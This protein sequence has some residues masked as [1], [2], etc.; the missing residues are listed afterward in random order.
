MAALVPRCFLIQIGQISL[1][2]V[3]NFIP[4]WYQDCRW[5]QKH[6]FSPP[7]P[8]TS[9]WKEL[10]RVTSWW[11]MLHLY[12]C[13]SWASVSWL[14][15]K[16]TFP[17]PISV[18]HSYIYSKGNK[19]FWTRSSLAKQILADWKYEIQTSSEVSNDLS[20]TFSSSEVAGH[21]T[22]WS[23]GKYF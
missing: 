17:L 16:G 7:S 4:T 2:M 6:N 9:V 22:T 10:P 19:T 18:I 11:V 12:I 3:I 23:S 21:Y 5:R 8:V 20:K 13:L 14:L 1:T 15:H